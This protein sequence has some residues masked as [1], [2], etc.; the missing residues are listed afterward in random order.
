MTRT[1]QDCWVLWNKSKRG[2]HNAKKET[3]KYRGATDEPA[4]AGGKADDKP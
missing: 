4:L 1:S 3:G 2:E